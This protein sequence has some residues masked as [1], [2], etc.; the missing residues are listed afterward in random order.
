MSDPNI[1]IPSEIQRGIELPLKIN[2]ISFVDSKDCLQV[3][4]ADI[5]AGAISYYGRA[6]L[7]GDK[8]DS[9]FQV[10]SESKI[11]K[12]LYLPIFPAHVFTPQTSTST[13]EDIDRVVDVLK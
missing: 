7:T 6:L 1:S 10:I 11:A 4:L 9:L 8:K 5:F 3:Q 2:N 13:N 12:L